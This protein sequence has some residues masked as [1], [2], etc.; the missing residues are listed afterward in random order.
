ML[1][2][3]CPHCLGYYQ[4]SVCR[5]THSVHITSLTPRFQSKSIS[6]KNDPISHCSVQYISMLFWN[7]SL[8]IIFLHSEWLGFLTCTMSFNAEYV[9]LL[10][11]ETIIEKQKIFFSPPSFVSW[12]QLH[13]KSQYLN[14]QLTPNYILRLSQW[15]LLD[16]HSSIL[17]G[18]VPVK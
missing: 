1:P 15:P 4:M 8:R 5:E 6:K 12:S 14:I 18:H 7:A 3:Y 11:K 17:S 13:C 2:W 16:L 10:R 9:V